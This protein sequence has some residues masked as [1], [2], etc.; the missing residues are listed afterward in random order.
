MLKQQ[1]GKVQEAKYLFLKI[2]TPIILQFK[3]YAVNHFT[4]RR[5]KVTTLLYQIYLGQTLKW[6]SIQPYNIYKIK[7]FATNI[8]A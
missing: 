1:N 8:T 5:Y 6:L 3:G 7:I 2:L 4:G